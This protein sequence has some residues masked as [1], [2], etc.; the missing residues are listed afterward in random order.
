[1]SSQKEQP[2]FQ[3][4]LQQSPKKLRI[5]IEFSQKKILQTASTIS[6]LWLTTDTE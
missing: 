2:I 1:M 3:A 5:G 6:N 4:L